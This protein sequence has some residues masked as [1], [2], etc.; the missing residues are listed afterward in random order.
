MSTTTSSRSSRPPV[1][2][3]EASARHLAE[4]EVSVRSVL[5][6]VER[7]RKAGGAVQAPP[8]PGRYDYLAQFA[9]FLEEIRADLEALEKRVRRA[10]A[11]LY[12]LTLE[13]S[14]AEPD[15]RQQHARAQL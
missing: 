15:G 12:G 11:L 5:S 9:G 2:E 14:H 7:V 3:L 8:S 4:A 1:E 10:E 13:A 6:H